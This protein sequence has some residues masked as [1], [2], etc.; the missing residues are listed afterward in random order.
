MAALS[1]TCIAKQLAFSPLALHSRAPSRLPASTRVARPICALKQTREIAVSAASGAVLLSLTPSAAHALETERILSALDQA[2]AYS[3]QAADVAVQAFDAAKS[4][5]DQVFDA[6]AP[7]VEAATPVVVQGA[8]AAAE[9]VAPYASDLAKEAQKALSSSGVELAPVISAAKTAA[10][11]AGDAFT[12]ASPYAKSTLETI[13]AQEPQVLAAGGG[14]LLLVYLIVPGL[15][16]SLAFSARDFT[17]AQA[18]DL[19]TKEDYTLVD[20]RTDTQRARTG[21]PALPRNAKKK[22]VAVPVEELP[23]KLRSQTRNARKVE[24]EITALKISSLKRL[25][26]GSKIIIIDQNG[27]SAKLV[28]QSLSALGLKKVWIVKDGMEGGSGWIQ[29]QLGTEEA[30]GAFGLA[31]VLLP[32]RVISGTRGTVQVPKSNK[33]LLPSGSD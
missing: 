28:A 22:L 6:A 23:N 9:A 26:K 12:A 30:S 11:V 21:V 10:G 18:L 19:L 29:S 4:V 16:S 1:N 33:F 8:K 3:Q 5:T 14:A 24:A 20:V 25:G 27:D 15:L 17:A 2:E 31:E 32:G 7:V 13:L